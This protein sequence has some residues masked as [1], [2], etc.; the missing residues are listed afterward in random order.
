MRRDE[1]AGTGSTPSSNST[2]PRV[3]LRAVGFGVLHPRAKCA[4]CGSSS[5]TLRVTK[6]LWTIAPCVVCEDKVE[7]SRRR[8]WRVAA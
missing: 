7:C 5:T 1:P 8:Y 2:R 3:A 4:W 6:L